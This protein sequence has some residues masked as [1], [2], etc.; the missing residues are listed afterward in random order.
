MI[1]EVQNGRIYAKDNVENVCE[2]EINGRK[3]PRKSDL[4][5]IQNCFAAG[6]AWEM[7]LSLLTSDRYIGARYASLITIVTR[8]S[9]SVTLELP[10]SAE[11]AG[12]GGP[13][14]SAGHLIVR[15]TIVMGICVLSETSVS[16]TR[17]Q[18]SVTI[19]R[20]RYLGV[21]FCGRPRAAIEVL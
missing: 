11:L 2:C 3:V 8:R 7:P 20:S 19:A 6:S 5:W 16:D 12:H 10:A 9:K 4:E 14:R 17:E 18:R 15:C 1:G 21:H 13:S